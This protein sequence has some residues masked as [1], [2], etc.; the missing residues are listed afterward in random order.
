M[1]AHC[2]LIAFWFKNHAISVLLVEKSFSDDEMIQIITAAV[3][4]KMEKKTLWERHLLAH[5][6]YT[7]SMDYFKFDFHELLCE[8]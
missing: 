6:R 8:K 3:E 5:V 2:F 7:K 4:H 1:Y